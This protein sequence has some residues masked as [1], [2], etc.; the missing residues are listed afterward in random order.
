MTTFDPKQYRCFI[1]RP[2]DDLLASK[3]LIKVMLLDTGGP[4]VSL[5]GQLGRCKSLITMA[6]GGL[7]WAE[8]LKE[9]NE[10]KK[11]NGPKQFTVEVWEKEGDEYHW[12]HVKDIAYGGVRWLKVDHASSDGASDCW[13]L[14]DFAYETRVEADRG[15]EECVIPAS[16]KYPVLHATRL[17]EEY[18]VPIPLVVFTVP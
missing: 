6:S 9:A 5:W 12:K 18:R 3:P 11:L 13:G 8:D 17:F 15:D 4:V 14:A 1:P 7:Y 16:E 2:V 10:S